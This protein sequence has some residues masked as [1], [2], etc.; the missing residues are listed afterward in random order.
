MNIL[1]VGHKGMLGGD[2]LVRLAMAGHEVTG[3]DIDELD[4]TSREACRD[5]VAET[6][7]DAVVNAAAYTNVDGCESDR[8]GCFSV[9]ARGV[10][11]LALACRERGVRIVHFSTDYI[12]DGRKGTPYAE[13][14]PGAPLN[15]YGESKL[16]GERLLLEATENVLLVRTS[17]LYGK[18]GKNFVRT[19][20]EKAAIT[21]RLEVVDDQIGCPTYSWDLAGAVNLLLEGGHRGIFHVTNR[22]SVSWYSFACK[23][24]EMAGKTGVTVSPVPTER[25]PRPAVRPRYSVLSGRKFLEATGK[26]LRFWQLA[27]V[28]YLSHA[29]FPADPGV[30]RH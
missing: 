17:W 23:I 19:I 13:D 4:I 25:F 27:L 30:S 16:E 26:T 15:V 11:N 3:M 5:A 12:F 6:G 9:N 21:D 24:M 8:D 28:E 2:L 1:V 20:L 22:G 18:G 14:D 29:G 10:E 7:P